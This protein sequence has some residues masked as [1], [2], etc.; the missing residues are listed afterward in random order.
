MCWNAAPCSRVWGVWSRSPPAPA[1]RPNLRAR[2]AGA[3]FV[4]RRTP[5]SPITPSS[6]RLVAATTSSRS[7]LA[8][9]TANSL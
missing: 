2:F 3:Y 5:T 4:P 6:I 9:R 1:F 7:P 8:T